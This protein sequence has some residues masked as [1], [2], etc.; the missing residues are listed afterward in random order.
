MP[1]PWNGMGRVKVKKDNSTFL[2]SKN[3][4]KFKILI[5]NNSFIDAKTNR[6]IDDVLASLMYY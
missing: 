6:V 5:S 4:L 2:T 1:M 3:K